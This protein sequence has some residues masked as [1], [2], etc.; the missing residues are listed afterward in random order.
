MKFPYSWLKRHINIDMDAAELSDMLTMSG[1]KVEGV[2]YPPVLKGLVVAEIIEVSKHPNADKLSLCRIDTGGREITVVCGAKNMKNGDKVVFAPA[3]TVLP[4]GTKLKK[5]VIRGVES[6]GMLCSEDELGLGKDHSGIIILQDSAD[7]GSDASEYLG[8]DTVFELEVTP[9]R[10]DCLS[11]MGV[12]REVAAVKNMELLKQDFSL[13]ESDIKASNCF[14]VRIEDKNRC[15]FYSARIIKGASVGE[16]PNWLKNYLKSSGIRPINNIVDVTNFILLD[17]GHPLHAFDMSL[18]KGKSIFVR[19]AKKNEKITTIDGVERKLDETVLIIADEKGPVALAGVMGGRDSEISANTKDVLLESAYFNPADIRNTSKR[20]ALTSESSYRFE[21]GADIG[22]V[23]KALDRAAAMISEL[24]GGMVLKA[25]LKDGAQERENPVISC[26]VEKANK[27]MGIQ[28]STNEICDIF[29]RL[30]IEVL[31]EDRDIIK[32]KAPTFRPDITE[33]A[34]LFEEIARIYGY[35][36]IDENLPESKIVGDGNYLETDIVEKMGESLRASGCSETMSFSFISARDLENCGFSKGNALKIKNP[37]NEELLYLRTSIL[38]GMMKTLS[39]NLNRDAKNLKLYEFGRIYFPSRENDSGSSEILTLGVALT[40]FRY[41]S[42][43]IEGSQNVNFFDI[44]GVIENVL[45]SLGIKNAEY[46]LHNS[47]TF[48][49]GNAAFIKIA[50][51]PVGSMGEL[52]KDF[53]RRYGIEQTVF[54]CELDVSETMK[55]YNRL[56][57]HIPFS[58]FPAVK[59]DIALI[60]DED[61]TYREVLKAAEKEKTGL[62]ENIEVFDLY[63]GRQIPENKKSLGISVTYR[64]ENSTLTDK[65]VDELHNKLVNRWVKELKCSIRDF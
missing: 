65:E 25:V 46:D 50:G 42:R 24:A 2:S 7:T 23:V 40:G 55:Y 4:C 60:L 51:V 30:E 5:A 44:K 10:P 27:L 21:R 47:V 8:I 43:W 22:I 36:S 45:D 19:P 32:I 34:D 18:L 59:R 29:R 53:C 35:D 17:M 52:D 48:K 39:Y 49:K 58:M 64:S 6:G 33:E 41:D 3:G 61:L 31:S 20:F 1:T 13:N 38:P 14:S 56:K 9:N 15:P 54:Y 57:K 26:R 63:K 12:A 62:I 16:S 37:Q 11:V 28:L